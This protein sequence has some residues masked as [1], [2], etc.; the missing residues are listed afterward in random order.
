VLTGRHACIRGPWAGERWRRGYLRNDS[1][2]GKKVNQCIHVYNFSKQRQ[3]LTKFYNN[4]MTSQTNHQISVK[5]VNVCKSCSKFSEV[6]RKP[7]CPLLTTFRHV[8]GVQK[9]NI[10]KIC[11]QNIIC[12]LKCKIKD[13]NVTASSMINPSSSCNS[14]TLR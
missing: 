3:I 8:T 10:F 1:M 11:V 2:S 14:L 5:F 9:S 7:E 6:T 4:N 13:V 12:V